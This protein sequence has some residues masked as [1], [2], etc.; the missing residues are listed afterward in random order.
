MATNDKGEDSMGS[1]T[2]ETFDQSNDLTY[3][4]TMTKTNVKTK[5]ILETCYLHLHF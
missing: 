1:A 5:G 2:F 3:T 4:K